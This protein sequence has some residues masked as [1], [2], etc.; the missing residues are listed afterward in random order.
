[1]KTVDEHQHPSKTIN[2]INNINILWDPSTTFGKRPSGRQPLWTTTPL[3]DNPLGRQSPLETLEANI[4]TINNIDIHAVGS[5][6]HR[7]ATLWTTT[8]GRQ[9][10]QHRPVSNSGLYEQACLLMDAQ[11]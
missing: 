11:L 4:N 6:Y 8:F 5:C 9:H 7:K 3:G 1:L 10:Q 2:S